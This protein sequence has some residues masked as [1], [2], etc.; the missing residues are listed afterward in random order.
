MKKLII[1]L[2]VLSTSF[3]SCRKVETSSIVETE[4]LALEN[5][6][7]VMAGNFS[8]SSERSTGSAK[9]YRQTNGKYVLGLEQMN[10][11]VSSTLTVY[12]S[13]SKTAYA[14]SIET[15]SVIN[16]S[17]DLFHIL[18]DNIDFATFKYLI[19]Q[20]EHSEEIVA[21]AILK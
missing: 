19:I 9:V 11:N 6:T 17:G 18:R 15:F 2:T 5:A 7:V 14:S 21:S 8:F 3:I 4:K 12:L 10:L 20:N 13:S 1:L 16:L